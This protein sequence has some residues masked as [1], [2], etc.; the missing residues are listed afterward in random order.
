MVDVIRNVSAAGVVPVISAGN[1]RD[2]FGMGTIGSPGSAP[3]AIS[4]AAVSNTHVFAPTLSVTRRSAPADVKRF[5][6]PA[7]VEPLSQRLCLRASP[8]RRRRRVDGIDGKPVDRRLCGPDD[9]TNNERSRSCGRDRSTATSR[10]PTADTAR[11][12][13]KRCAQPAPAP[14]RSCS[15]TTAPA[16]P[17]GFPSSLPLPAGMITDYD[18]AR[19]RA[20][21][22]KQRQRR[23]RDDR[24]SV[25]ARRE[26]PERRGHELLVGWPDRLRAPA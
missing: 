11:S 9:D 20:Y 7:Q 23:R 1:D 14:S 21:L 19:L 10:S 17:T 22:A 13:R 15:S 3:D 26:R 18:G 2:N 12:S 25:R 16:A 5:R 24:N 4:V 6:S 8:P